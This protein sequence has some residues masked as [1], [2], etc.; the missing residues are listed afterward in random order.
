MWGNEGKKPRPSQAGLQRRLELERS[1]QTN[2]EYAD[3]CRAFDWSAGLFVG[4]G[5]YGLKN[6][7]GE[8]LLPPLYDEFMHLDGQ[9][10]KPGDRVV[11]CF[12]GSWGIVVAGQPLKWLVDPIYDYI[13][14]PDDIA[15][16]FIQGKWGVMNIPE[17]RYIIGPK[18]EEIYA[19]KGKFFI[20]GIGFFRKNGKFG[21]ITDLGRH[22]QPVFDDADMVPSG[23][24]KVKYKDSWG[25]ID[26]ND[27]FT[28]DEY[29]AFYAFNPE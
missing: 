1:G 5:L 13:G 15:P 24:V 14:Y 20:N 22:T 10:L 7:A 23:W 4:N 12:N 6:A 29:K 2:D 3:L 21:V 9:F 28:L 17:G 8:L 27:Q 25:F 11:A 19:D 18:C 16:V 26:E